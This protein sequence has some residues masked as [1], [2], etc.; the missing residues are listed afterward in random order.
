M[1]FTIN[2]SIAAQQKLS[3]QLVASKKT[4]AIVPTMGALHDGHI[5]LI[6]RGLKLAD[7]VVTTIF[8]NP[9]QFGPGEDFKRYPRN[10]KADVEI[11]R[12]TGGQVVFIPKA[13][14][15]Y[16]EEY[17]TYVSVHKL[18]DDLEGGARPTH[19]RGVTTV[20]TKLFN[21]VRPDVALFGMKDYQQAMVLKRMVADLNWPIRMVICPTVREKDG[22]AMSSRNRYLSP[23]LRQQARALY[24][25]LR[26]ARK[27]CMEGEERISV[28]L[29]DMRLTLRELAPAGKVDYIAFTD[30]ETLRPVTRIEK[31]TVASLAV[32]LGPVR[33]IDNMKIG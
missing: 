6:K 29:H 10:A 7:V 3:R 18:T 17:R 2:K 4:I 30:M 26:L 22:L 33:L 1:K 12:N 15:M 21:I 20:V 27:L 31:D 8:V 11:I 25:A 23:E 32:R 19:F 16:P 13:Q 5:S 14:D 9:T 24:E 28:I